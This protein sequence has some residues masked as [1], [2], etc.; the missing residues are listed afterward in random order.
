MYTELPAFTPGRLL[1]LHYPGLSGIT[2]AMLYYRISTPSHELCITEHSTCSSTS[3]SIWYLIH[4]ICVLK[5]V[6]Y[7]HV[8][9]ATWRLYLSTQGIIIWIIML[10]LQRIHSWKYLTCSCRLHSHFAIS[11]ILKSVL[12]FYNLDPQCYAAWQEIQG[13]QSTK[14]L[15]YTLIRLHVMCH[16]RQLPL[17]WRSL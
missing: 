12:L 4:Y 7:Q 1:K 3:L 14:P 9:S 13:L 5:V 8:H 10:M 16:V 17:H 15:T 6:V 11:C 2:H